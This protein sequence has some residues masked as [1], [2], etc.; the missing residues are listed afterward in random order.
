MT[1][2]SGRTGSQADT[3]EQSREKEQGV[4]V[5]SVAAWRRR[6]LRQ[7]PCVSG[8]NAFATNDFHFPDLYPGLNAKEFKA[9]QTHEN[10]HVEF[11]VNALGASARPSPEFVDL[12]QETM[13]DFVLTSRALENTGVGAYLG[14]APY[15]SSSGYLA[16]AG[17]ILTIEARHSGYINVLLNLLMTDNV[18]GNHQ[19]FELPL[20]QDLVIN[21]AGP[22]IANL[23][24]GPPLS[25]STT[26]S[27][28]NDIAILNFALA[29]EYL[30][31]AFYNTNV[32]I[33]FP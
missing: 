5:S 21:L 30:E 33:F 24:G 13:V 20:T 1:G 32:P 23:N 9:I 2:R 16:A 17:S 10:A 14:A 11:L 12:T 28:A 29:L 26:P 6:P 4:E 19:S 25:F 22:F 15:I 18:Y 27:P 3:T 31:A 7:R 8:R